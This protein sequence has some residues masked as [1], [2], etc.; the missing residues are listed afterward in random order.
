ML[1]AFVAVGKC[2]SS[3]GYVFNLRALLPFDSFLGDGRWPTDH[4]RIVQVAVYSSFQKGS[5]FLLHLDTNFIDDINFI[6]SQMNK[7]CKCASNDN[8]STELQSSLQS[9]CI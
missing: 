2:S 1:R 6:I 3:L 9:K 5:I 7:C 4:Q 8:A